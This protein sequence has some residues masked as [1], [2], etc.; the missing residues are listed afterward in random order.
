MWAAVA[1]LSEAHREAVVLRYA[2]GL[3]YEEI[4]QATS[5]P[6]GTVKSRLS[7]ARAILR[8]RLKDYGG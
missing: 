8:D 4:A 7:R 3:S 1:S 2:E 5:C 6:I